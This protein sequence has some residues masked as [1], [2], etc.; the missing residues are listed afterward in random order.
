METTTAFK[1]VVPL[2]GSEVAEQALPFA[3]SLA[4]AS[5]EICLIRV[6][7][8]P[9]PFYDDVLRR[10]LPV[11]DQDHE[12]RESDALQALVE[13][14]SNYETAGSNV[15]FAVRTGDPAEELLKAADSFE[16]DM[17]VMASHGRGALDRWR[18]GSVADRVARTSRIPVMIV[19]ANLD[20]AVTATPRLKR[21][22]LAHDGSE[23]A[24][25]AVPFTVTLSQRLGLPVRV[26]RAID[27]ARIAGGAAYDLPFND[28]VVEQMETNVRSEA[29][30]SISSVLQQLQAGGVEATGEVIVGP[31]GPALLG[32]AKPGDLL[33]V[34][35]HNRC[36]VRR[37]LLGSVA[38]KLVRLAEVPVLLVPADCNPVDPSEIDRA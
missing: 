22:V 1:L 34:T 35:S 14:T 23:L 16:A 9:D 25:R 10:Y 5:G 29:E 33:I 8:P 38:E 3:I 26:V 30:R 7:S 17:I 31:A 19:R 24:D 27:P 4:G 18:F 11:T 37:W 13:T 36:G 12:R 6:A 21:L 2:D 28:A 20:S 15:S 32:F